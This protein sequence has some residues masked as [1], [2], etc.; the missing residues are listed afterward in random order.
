MEEEK[1]IT[2]YQIDSELGHIKEY[3]SRVKDVKGDLIEVGVFEGGS[4]KLLAEAYPKRT[5]YLFDT[6]EGLPDKLNTTMGDVKSYYVGHAKAELETC[7]EYLKDNKNVKIYKGVF[8]ESGE[9]VKDKTFCFAHI[10]VDI[11][12]STKESLEFI[13][14]RMNKGGILL[15]HDYP[16]HVGVKNAVDEFMKDKS[17]EMIQHGE[18]VGLPRQLFIIKS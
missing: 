18:E 15:V 14:P 8:P 17:D 11:Y 12:E 13:Y 3:L 6:F 9:P 2:I 1:E 5:V 10:D 16:V 7:K 4:A